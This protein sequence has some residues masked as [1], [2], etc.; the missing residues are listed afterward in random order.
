VISGDTRYFVPGYGLSD[1]KG[2]DA[3]GEFF[4]Q[5]TTH[6]RQYK[7]WNT[8][9]E[10]TNDSGYIL[11]QKEI[12]GKLEWVL[13]GIDEFGNAIDKVVTPQTVSGVALPYS[14]AVTEKYGNTAVRDLTFSGLCA[15]A[16]L[17]K[18]AAVSGGFASGFFSVP[19]ERRQMV[20]YN[21][22]SGDRKYKFPGV[23]VKV[24]KNSFVERG[25]KYEQTYREGEGYYSRG[26]SNYTLEQGI[27]LEWHLDALPLDCCRRS[28]DVFSWLMTTG[29]PD[30]DAKHTVEG[31]G[32]GRSTWGF[33]GAQ[34]APPYI[35]GRDESI[36]EFKNISE[37]TTKSDLPSILTFYIAGAPDAEKNKQHQLWSICR[38]SGGGANSRFVDRETRTVTEYTEGSDEVDVSKYDTDL[39]GFVDFTPNEFSMIPSRL[40][41]GDDL[42]V[43]EQTITVETSTFTAKVNVYHEDYAYDDASGSWDVT[44][45]IRLWYDL[46]VKLTR[47]YAQ[48][49]GLFIPAETRATYKRVEKTPGTYPGDIPTVTTEGVIEDPDELQ[50]MLD[51]AK[52][53]VASCE[54]PATDTVGDTAIGRWANTGIRTKLEIKT[55]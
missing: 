49:G 50:T 41:I 19:D 42:G 35:Y 39:P 31:S 15:H 16:P 4:Q 11:Q 38:W 47:T 46:E 3:L 5:Q 25:E 51:A 55:K 18:F 52:A 17:G 36:T 7:G 44:T 14:P 54:L 12:D 8:A 33:Y 37:E 6:T 45:T 27:E 34:G 20:P 30:I 53:D 10:Y 40:K 22:T 26:E 29:K 1:Y 21:G 48:K 28:G 24:N 13:P 23:D 43:E 32:S 2:V 9:A